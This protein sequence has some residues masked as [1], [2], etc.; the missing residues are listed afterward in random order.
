MYIINMKAPKQHP[1]WERVKKLIKAHKTTKEGS[2]SHAGINFSTL[3]KW[4]CYSITPD[5]YSA[6][7]ITVALG[8]PMEYLVTGN[9]GEAIQSRE[10]ETLIGKTADADIKKM[11]IQTEKDANL[12]A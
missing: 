7:D 8:V 11:A 6:Y 3:K 12:L 2:A 1:F 4:I 9:D 5:L 10:E